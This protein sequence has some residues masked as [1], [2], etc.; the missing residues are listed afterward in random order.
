MRRLMHRRQSGDVRHGINEETFA[1]GLPTFGRSLPIGGQRRDA[2][3]QH[4]IE[5]VQSEDLD[6][7]LES[8]ML[9]HGPVLGYIINGVVDATQS[10]RSENCTI[11]RRSASSEAN[12]SFRQPRKKDMRIVVEQSTGQ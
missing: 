9:R 12:F 8:G 3:V 4:L 2:N 10:G 6:L 5:C 11:G 7:W 1:R